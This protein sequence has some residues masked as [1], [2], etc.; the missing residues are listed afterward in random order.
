[1]ARS[2]T[3]T[4]T[5]FLKALKEYPRDAQMKLQ[6]Y[7]DDVE[8]S[9]ERLVPN[10]KDYLCPVYKTSARAGILSTGHSTNFR[11]AGDATNKART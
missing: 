8:L 6:P 1:V 2:R 7:S 10:A 9:P 3:L 11:S 5:D 4:R